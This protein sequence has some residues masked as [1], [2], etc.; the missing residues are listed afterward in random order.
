MVTVTGVDVVHELPTR[1]T[2]GASAGDTR[3]TLMLNT[4]VAVARSVAKSM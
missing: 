4:D 1:L 3:T 2:N